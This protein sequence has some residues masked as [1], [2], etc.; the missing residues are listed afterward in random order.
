VKKTRL[1]IA[2]V[3]SLG[4]PA[5]FDEHRGVSMRPSVR[6]AIPRYF[7]M[8]PFMRTYMVVTLLLAG[9]T[10]AQASGGVSCD[11]KDASVEFEA[12][13]GLGRSVGGSLFNVN[14]EIKVKLKGVPADFREL[15]F[16]DSDV[17]QRWIDGKEVRLQLYREREEGLFGYVNLEILTK[18][19]DEGSY[20]GRYEL[21]ISH[22]ESEKATE[23]KKFTARGKV[24][25]MTE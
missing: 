12:G 6:P 2:L 8:R 14:G 19:V 17:S 25:C 4:R 24:K 1:F 11:A 22:L 3:G 10:S 9:L 21:T 5:W 13:G 15:K 23:A 20:V 16:K 7:K 18:R